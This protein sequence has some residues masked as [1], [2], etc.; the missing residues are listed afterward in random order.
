MV[1]EGTMMRGY[2]APSAHNDHI[3]CMQTPMEKQSL[4][5]DEV[6][7]HLKHEEITG[8]QD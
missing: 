5:E 8:E 4:V 6:V 3:H 7:I 2:V 1:V